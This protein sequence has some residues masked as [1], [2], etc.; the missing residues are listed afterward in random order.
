MIAATAFDTNAAVA[1]ACGIRLVKRRQGKSLASPTVQVT[2]YELVRKKVTNP[3]IT[4]RAQ[5]EE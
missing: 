5:F 1:T 4:L 2:Y 3:F